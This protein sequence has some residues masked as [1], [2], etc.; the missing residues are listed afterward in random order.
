[1]PQHRIEKKLECNYRRL[2]F[3]PLLQNQAVH[4]ID[5]RRQFFKIYS[6][7]PLCL[8]LPIPNPGHFFKSVADIESSVSFIYYNLFGFT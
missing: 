3:N 4:C 1:M 8:A 7:L 6:A 5:T 2:N